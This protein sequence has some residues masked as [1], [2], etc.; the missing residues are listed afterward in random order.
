ML[1]KKVF[2]GLVVLVVVAMLSI[3]GLAFALA[4]APRSTQPVAEAAAS[5]TGERSITV[6]GIGKVAGTPDI[7]RVTVG[8]ETQAP[9]LQKAVDDNK[10]KMNGLLETL[11]QLGLADKDIRTSNYSVYTERVAPPAS[12][13]EVSTDQMIYHVTNQ[14]DVTVRD[15]NQIGN[16]LDEAVAAGANN[17]YGVNFSVEDT[18]KLEADARAKAVAD[19]QARAEELAQLNGVQ[20]GE[21][22]TVSEVVGGAVPL[23]REAAMGLGG[24]G[25]TPVQPGELEMSASIQITYAVK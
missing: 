10:V 3:G 7:A 21:V 1:A 8:I 24:G 23:Y 19:G 9:S 22:L 4:G 15:V 18:A 6:V 2:Y 25:G 16:V 11:K 5:T 13:V 12:G 14:V 17:I 20:L